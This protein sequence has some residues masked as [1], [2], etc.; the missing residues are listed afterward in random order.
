MGNT[1]SS[2]LPNALVLDTP[3][4]DHQHAQL[5]EKLEIFKASCV[6]HNA[7]MA[8]EAEEIFG[9]LVHHCQTEERLAGEA[10]LDFRSHGDKHRAMLAGIRKRLDAMEHPEADVY[11]L[12]RYIE[13]W[14][15]RHIKEEDR[16]LAD[17]LH[18]VAF[19][20]VG[21]QIAAESQGQRTPC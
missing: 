6:D 16:N 15:E 5:F 11:G 9:T 21:Q 20:G 2:Y 17:S 12:I 19:S 1:S 18:R 14:F 10:G 8:Q 4:I 3:E 7:F 13:Y